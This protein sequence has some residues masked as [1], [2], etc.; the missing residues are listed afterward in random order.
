MNYD[1]T[2]YGWV[3]NRDGKDYFRHLDDPKNEIEVSGDKMKK[4]KI[5][6]VIN[7]TII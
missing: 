4:V 5:K 3:T 6:D 2:Q 1:L 7:G